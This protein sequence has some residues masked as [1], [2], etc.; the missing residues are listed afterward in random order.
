MPVGATTTTLRSV[1]EMNRRISVD[2]PVPALP[3]R[4]T[5]RPPPSS[6]RASLNSS[7]RT[8][9]EL[10]TS[11]TAMSMTM[12]HRRVTESGRVTLLDDLKVCPA[13]DP[14]DA[15][16]GSHGVEQLDELCGRECAHR[17]EHVE[18]P[19]RASHEDHRRH[20]LE[21]VDDLAVVS[22]ESDAETHCALP[23]LPGVPHDG[24]HADDLRFDQTDDAPTSSGSREAD[25]LGE[26]DVGRA[27]VILQRTQQGQVDG[28]DVG[29]HVTDRSDDV[30]DHLDVGE[31]VHAGDPVQ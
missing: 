1:S 11:G 27:A 18:A 14:V 17:H 30:T 31:R 24:A 13:V 16:Q 22:G 23:I 2:L 8:S 25:H 5:C 12:S 15:W 6:A 19:E 21:L 4:N 26:V 7:V 20:G 3:V 28:V 10:R 29:A 9:C